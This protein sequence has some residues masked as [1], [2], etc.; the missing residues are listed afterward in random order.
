MVR[1]DDFRSGDSRHVRHLRTCVVSDADWPLHVF[2]SRPLKAERL[3]AEIRA[4][5]DS[6]TCR[7]RPIRQDMALLTGLI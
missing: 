1:A 6:L 4:D 7:C 2:V 3:F 5:F